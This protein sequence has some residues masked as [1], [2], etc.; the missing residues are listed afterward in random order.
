MLSRGEAGRLA[1]FLGLVLG[2]RGVVEPSMWTVSE[3]G[4]QSSVGVGEMR[5][6]PQAVCVVLYLPFW[7]EILK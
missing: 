2:G 7:L 1:G 3:L 4:T 6:V 5:S